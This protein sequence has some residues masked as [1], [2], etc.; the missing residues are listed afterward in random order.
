M[1]ETTTTEIVEAEQSQAPAPAEAQETQTQ[2]EQQESTDDKAEWLRNK[3]I[4]PSDPDAIHKAAEAWRKAEQEFHKSRQQKGELQNEAET[5][6][7][8]LAGEDAVLARMNV[9]EMRQTV[10]DFFDNP[11]YPGAS[12]LEPQMAEIVRA[13][14][15]L[16]QDLEAV[17]ALAKQSKHE[18]DVEAAKEAGRQEA[19]AQIA[20]ASVAGTPRGNASVRTG[21]KS[22]DEERLERFSNW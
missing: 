3:G 22:V 14:P 12:E 21:D 17:Y 19:K 7:R 9:L 8:D 16:A 4:D 11:N 18:A 1:D 5:A 6:A 10:R 13:R 20:K 15:Y 2:A